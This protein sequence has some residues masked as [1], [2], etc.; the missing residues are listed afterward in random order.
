M[1]QRFLRYFR[2]KRP[3][4]VKT[5]VQGFITTASRQKF[6]EHVSKLD[7]EAARALRNLVY[8]RLDQIGPP[9]SPPHPGFTKSIRQ[10]EDIEEHLIGLSQRRLKPQA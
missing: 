7:E 5:T 8:A 6:K 1:K 10:L 2:W 9:G 3:L 4:E